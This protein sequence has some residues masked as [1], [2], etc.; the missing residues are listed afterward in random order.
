MST[1]TPVRAQDGAGAENGAQLQFEAIVFE[2]QGDVVELRAVQDF[3]DPF[4]PE[5]PQEVVDQIERLNDAQQEEAIRGDVQPG[6]AQMRVIVPAQAPAVRGIQAIPGIPMQ[7]L[8]PAIRILPAL[9][10][11]PVPQSKPF[12]ESVFMP[13]PSENPPLIARSS[14]W[15]YWDKHEAPPVAWLNDD[16]DDQSWPAGP[17]PLGYNELHLKTAI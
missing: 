6:Q 15:R 3:A 8:R 4:P 5:L 13:D 9:Q 1:H 10:L 7:Q 12:D 11:A 16:F 17:A 2:D 14:T